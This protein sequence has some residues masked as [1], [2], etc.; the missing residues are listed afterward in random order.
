MGYLGWAVGDFAPTLP[1][2]RRQAS[3]LTPNPAL[4]ALILL[5]GLATSV[6]CA[7]FINHTIFNVS[8]PGFHLMMPLNLTY[9]NNDTKGSDLQ[10][11]TRSPDGRGTIDIIPNCT[12][13][14]FL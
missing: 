4:K 8:S 5:L 12:T 7:K 11:W 1:I 14:I 6:K 9:V 10:G 3:N 2:S 13:T